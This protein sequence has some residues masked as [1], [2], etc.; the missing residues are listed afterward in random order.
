MWK[1]L[2]KQIEDGDIYDALL[3][4]VMIG[5]LALGV[6]GIVCFTVFKVAELFAGGS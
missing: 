3:I 5:G 6:I 1:A 4:L 2:V